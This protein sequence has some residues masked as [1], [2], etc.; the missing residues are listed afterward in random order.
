MTDA[1]VQADILRLRRGDRDAVRLLR[2]CLDGADDDRL[3]GWADYVS[4]IETA[5]EV[6]S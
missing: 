5:A 6:A 4:A 1:D 2:D 3:G